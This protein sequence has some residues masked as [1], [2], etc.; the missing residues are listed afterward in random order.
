V[1]TL[2][3]LRER[4]AVPAMRDPPLPPA[5]ASTGSLARDTVR[6]QVREYLRGMLSARLGDASAAERAAVAVERSAG[7]WENLAASRR[8]AAGVRA[9]LALSRGDSAAALTLL[10]RMRIEEPTGYLARTP[11]YAAVYERLRLGQLLRRAGREEEAA[12][13][14]AALGATADEL[15]YA[16]LAQTQVTD[17][18]RR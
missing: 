4:L 11:F 10:E 18:G 16:A 5:S 13:W 14:L 3:E 8:L 15:P 2:R 6:P 1:A 9:E 17:G 7:S 12:R